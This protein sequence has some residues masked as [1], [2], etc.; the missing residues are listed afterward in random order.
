MNNTPELEIFRSVSCDQ[1]EHRTIRH[2][3]SKFNDDPYLTVHEF[4][5]ENGEYIGYQASPASP[6][7]KQEADW[8]NQAFDRDPVIEVDDAT[9]ETDSNGLVTYK[10]KTWLNKTA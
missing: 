4:Y 8:I 7:S 5:I 3:N 9:S 1:W 2:V 6:M 10:T